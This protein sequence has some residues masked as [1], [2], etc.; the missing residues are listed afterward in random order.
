MQDLN[1]QKARF[2]IGNGCK[3][4]I[5][6]FDI[7]IDA[8][9]SSAFHDSVISHLEYLHSDDGW[10]S[11]IFLALSIDGEVETAL[12]FIKVHGIEINLPDIRSSFFSSIVFYVARWCDYGDCIVME[13]DGDLVKIVAE[14]IVVLQ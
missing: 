6:N 1:N 9:G 8:Y 5:D 2:E 10:S 11:D 4:F 13:T 7:L 14:K 12:R 3:P